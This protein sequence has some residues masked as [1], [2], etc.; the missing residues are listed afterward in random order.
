MKKMVKLFASCMILLIVCAF[1][2]TSCDGADINGI[3]GSGV[4]EETKGNNDQSNCLHAFSE[5]GVDEPANCYANGCE[6]RICDNCAYVE[7]RV[8][9]ALGHNWMYLYRYADAVFSKEPMAFGACKTCGVTGIVI[10]S[11][12][13]DEDGDSL[14]NA[15]EFELGRRH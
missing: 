13:G 5:W 3:F 6:S 4:D 8:V 7:E 1:V 2:M 9:Q 12:E 10:L 14:T 11:L 15:K